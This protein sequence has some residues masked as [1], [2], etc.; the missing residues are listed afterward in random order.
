NP[1]TV[2]APRQQSDSNDEFEYLPQR[3][4]ALAHRK[5]LGVALM[6]RLKLSPDARPREP[7]TREI[8]VVRLGNLGWRLIFHV[9]RVDGTWFVQFESAELRTRYPVDKLFWWGGYAWNADPLDPQPR[10]TVD[11][12]L[13]LAEHGP[14]SL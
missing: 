2:T 5:Q 13:C 4:S 14:D 3:L 7:L 1:V 10:V 12:R 11:I 6:G 8:L 9:C